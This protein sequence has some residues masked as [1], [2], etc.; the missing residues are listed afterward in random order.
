MEL[1]LGVC[2]AFPH[3]NALNGSVH[4]ADHSETWNKCWGRLQEEF[5]SNMWSWSTKFLA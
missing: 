3:E 2:N 5:G 1:P 4:L